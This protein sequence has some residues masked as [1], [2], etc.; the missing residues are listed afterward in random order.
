MTLAHL[1]IRPLLHV[2]FFFFFFD[3]KN[4]YKKMSLKDPN[5]FRKRKENRQLKMAKLQFLKSLIFPRA[6]Q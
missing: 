3:K 5:L 2:F 6:L 4:I 1:Y